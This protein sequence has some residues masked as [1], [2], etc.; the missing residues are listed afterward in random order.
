MA[1]RTVRLLLTVIDIDAIIQQ[2]RLFLGHPTLAITTV[3]AIL[4]VGGGIGSGL[5]YEELPAPGCRLPGRG[6]L[7]RPVEWCRAFKRGLLSHA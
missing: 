3:L 1:T 2:V 7:S 4:L 5:A 6:A